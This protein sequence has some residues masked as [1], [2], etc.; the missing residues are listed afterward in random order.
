[1]TKREACKLPFG[2]SCGGLFL[3]SLSE[4][5]RADADDGAALFDGDGVVVG[6]TLGELTES[7]GICKVG[8]LEFIEELFHLA[9]LATHLL[10]I[11]GVAT[12][13]HEARDAHVVQIA[14]R[15]G[16]KHR[17]ALV[18]GEAKLGVFLC[19]VYL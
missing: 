5:H 19:D 11:V 18:D 14:P 13:S 12:H 17:A 10:H 15:L 16:S 1:M 3:L 4:Y 2:G 7:I 8:A 9:E 6:H